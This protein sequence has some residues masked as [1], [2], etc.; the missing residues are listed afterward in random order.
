MLS[1]LVELKTTW[2]LSF[3]LFLSIV[4]TSQIV[5]NYKSNNIKHTT[6]TF[7]SLLLSLWIIL[8]LLD[9]MSFPHQILDFKF[10]FISTFVPHFYSLALD[11]IESFWRPLCLCFERRL[12][13]FASF[14]RNFPPIQRHLW[15]VALLFDI[16]T[17]NIQRLMW[18]RLRRSQQ[19][20]Q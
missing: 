2:R 20:L 5:L 13:L 4:K 17:T 8:C 9:R 15:F 1:F 10:L 12:A 14:F 7:L 19:R 18:C 3:S 16:Y 11:V 6:Y